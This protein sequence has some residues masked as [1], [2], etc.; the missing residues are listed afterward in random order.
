MGQQAIEHAAL[1]D[2]LTGEQVGNVLA[3]S[4][5]R[6]DLRP[7]LDLLQ[8]GRRYVHVHTHP[9]GSSFSDLDLTVL[10]AYVEIRTLVV[11][12]QDGAWY[13]LSKVRGQPSA[14]PGTGGALWNTCFAL[15]AQPHHALIARGILSH[16]EALRDEV[17][18]TMIRL[19]PEIGLRYDWLEAVG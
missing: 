5:D 12:A 2:A 11:V 8:P 9:A 7:H 13:F 16:D 6:L 17:H 3:G 1:I 15:M 19:A 18:E 4:E 14:D 10:L